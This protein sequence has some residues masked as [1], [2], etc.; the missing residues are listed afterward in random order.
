M[1]WYHVVF[2]VALIVLSIVIVVLIL[3]QESNQQGLSGA[4]SGGSSDSFFGKNKGRTDEAKKAFLTKILVAVFSVIV[5][6]SV[7]VMIFVK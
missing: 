6:A 3:L 1:A 4:I 7:L 2:G 5:L